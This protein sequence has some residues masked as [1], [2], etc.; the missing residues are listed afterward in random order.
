[1]A[2]G[3][4]GN[5]G[6][7]G[8]E[9]RDGSTSS[10]PCQAFYQVGPGEWQ[11]CHQPATYLGVTREGTWALSSFLCQAHAEYLACYGGTPPIDQVTPVE[12]LVA[13]FGFLTREG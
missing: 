12:V 7:E 3:N 8:N 1:V 11:N 4:Q 10:L 5:W 2:E 13:P 9:G 6:N